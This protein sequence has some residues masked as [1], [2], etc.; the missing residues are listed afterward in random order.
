MNRVFFV[1]VNIWMFPKIVGFCPQII[2]FNVVF[3]YF[4][5][6]FW[7]TY[8][9][10]HRNVTKGRLIVNLAHLRRSSFELSG[11]FRWVHHK[12]QKD[13]FR[14]LELPCRFAGW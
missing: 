10:K 12:K 9:W 11:F 13:L 7:G 3:H 8:F 6:P 5:H 2:H 1:E 4:H 14:S